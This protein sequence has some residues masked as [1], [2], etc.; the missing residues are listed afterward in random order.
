MG[1]ALHMSLI[2]M[3]VFQMCGGTFVVILLQL[4]YCRFLYG[5]RFKVMKFWISHT[6]L[7][8][9]RYLITVSLAGYY[10]CSINY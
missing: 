9:K 3:L 4:A 2:F 7:N 5:L 1:V 6:E 8:S 10:N